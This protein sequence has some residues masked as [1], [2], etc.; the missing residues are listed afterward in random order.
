M[1]KAAFTDNMQPLPI[2]CVFYWYYYPFKKPKPTPKLNKSPKTPI[3]PTNNNKKTSTKPQVMF[4]SYRSVAAAVK[5]WSCCA[6]V[7][8]CLCRA[9]GPSG[10]FV[11]SQ[12]SVQVPECVMGSVY[13]HWF[14]HKYCRIGLWVWLM[15]ATY[16]GPPCLQCVGTGTGFVL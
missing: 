15:S 8:L 9:V 11:L 10:V 13:V 16:Q 2:C 14:A 1:R 6:A 4:A 5:P 3:Q 7:G 12:G